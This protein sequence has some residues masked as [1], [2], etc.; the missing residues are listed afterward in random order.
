ML[1]NSPGDGAG[2]SDGF[3]SSAP[4]LIT[5]VNVII[6]TARLK[7]INFFFIFALPPITL[8]FPFFEVA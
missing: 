4:V 1:I 7:P 6:K 5:D 8:F 2:A 3:A